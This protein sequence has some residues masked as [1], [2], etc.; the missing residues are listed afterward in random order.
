VLQTNRP[1]EVEEVRRMLDAQ[2][3]P[4]GEKRPN[5]TETRYARD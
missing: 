4:V 1:G 5:E 2:T 3:S